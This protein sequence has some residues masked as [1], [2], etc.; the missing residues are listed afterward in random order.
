[1]QFRCKS[2][3]YCKPRFF[4]CDGVNDCGDNSDEQDCKCPDKFLKCRNGKCIPEAQKCDNTDNCG[5]GTDESDC[6]LAQATSCTTYTYKC[7]NDQCINK[8][9]PECD[10][11]SDCTDGSDE[12]MCDCGKRPYSRKT[13]IVGGVNADVGEW[14]WQVSLQTKKDGHTCG[15][16]LVSPTMLLSAAHCFQDSNSVRYSDPS[17]WTAYLGLHDQSTKTSSKDVVMRKIKRVVANRGFNDFTYDN[18]IA[19][20]ELESPVTYTDFIQPIC[21]PESTHVFPVGKSIWVTGW[22]ALSEGGTG[23]TVLQKAEI[24]II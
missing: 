15:A 12:T 24:R 3:Q 21:I 19:M 20:L 4:L 13:R 11:V 6:G 23:A 7:K 8:L 9:N 2:S 5:D 16:S 1:K 22:G 10:G 17:V 18:D 14:P